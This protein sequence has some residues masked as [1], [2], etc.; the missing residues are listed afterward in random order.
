MKILRPQDY[1]LL[2]AFYFVAQQAQAEARKHEK[3]IEELLGKDSGAVDTISDMIYNPASKGTKK[4]IDEILFDKHGIMIE[5]KPAQNKF[6]NQEQ[7]SEKETKK[8]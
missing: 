3:L 5:W 1:Y 8:E 6:A 7:S 4:E 2:L